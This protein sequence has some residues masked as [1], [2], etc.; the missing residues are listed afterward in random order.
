MTFRFTET[1]HTPA[2]YREFALVSINLPGR[3]DHMDFA[4]LI[5]Y[6]KVV[7]QLYCT[8]LSSSRRNS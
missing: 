1:I 8:T 2:E 3:L 7:L 5:Y 6:L 4:I